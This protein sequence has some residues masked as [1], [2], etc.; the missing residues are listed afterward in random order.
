V[1]DWHICDVFPRRWIDLVVVLRA[2]TSVL[3]DR[4]TSR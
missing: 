1:I 4:L 2:E 3:Y